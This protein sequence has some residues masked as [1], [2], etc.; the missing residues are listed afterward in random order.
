[1]NKEKLR[2]KKQLDTVRRDERSLFD[3][4]LKPGNDDAQISWLL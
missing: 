4:I 1:M 2:F 3:T